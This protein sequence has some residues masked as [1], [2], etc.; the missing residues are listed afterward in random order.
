MTDSHKHSDPVRPLSP[1]EIKLVE[2]IDRSWTRERAL[3]ELKEHLQIAIE[4]ELATIPIYLYTYYSIDRTPASFPDSALSRFA[5]QAGAVIMSVAVEEMLHMSLSSN[6]LF[7]LGVQ[8]QLYLRSP[9]PYPTNLPGHQKLGPDAR[10]LALPLAPFSLQQLWQFL[11]I[12]Y[13]AASDAPPQGGAW[14]TIG[15]IY[16]YVRCIISC[17]HI[18]DADFHQGARLRQIQSTNYSPNNIDTVF[19]GGSFDKTCPVPAP[20][21]GSAATVAVYPSRGDSHAG[22]AQLITIDSRE[23]AL[24]AI[25][26]IDAQGE[27]FGTSK[28]D[29][30][31]KQEESHYYKF[32]SLQSQLAGYD[33]QHEHLP[34][35]PK[36]PAPAAR[37]FTPEELAQVVFDFP[38]NPV[39]SAYPAGRR[40]LA[41]VV[42]GLY[43]YM[44]I[45]TETIFLQEPARQ[46]LYFNQALH[47]SMIWILDKVIRTMRGVF[48]QQSSS[49]TGNPRLAPT[50]ENLD[51]GPRDQAFATLVTMCSELD[52]RYGNEPWYSQDLKYYVDMVPSLP[53]VS[54]FWAA[55]AQPGCDVSKYTG[56]PKFPASP[57][58]TVGDNEVRHACMGLNHCAGQGRTRDNACAG[59]GYCSTALEYNYAQPASPTVSDHTCHVKN[60]CAGQGGCGLYGTGEEQND[61]GHN[62]CATLGSCATP[63][64]AE[65]F[66]TD[67]PNRGKGVWLRARE[68]F[69]QKT[70]PSLRH[71]Q[72]KLPAQPPAVPHAQ[73]FQ[74][75]PTIEWIQ[76]YSGEGMTACGSSGMSGAG[77]CA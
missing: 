40:E 18:T 14:T 41:N 38:D 56:V 17:R 20:V 36:P 28:F 71:Q 32:L 74:Y 5:D 54:A 76:D 60:A 73:L 57:P 24:Q 35:H 4:V 8:P 9:A 21:A 39:A 30:P 27:G 19:P 48:L 65:R 51:L 69:T 22:R 55:P 43:Q 64:N 59:Q 61:P 37:Q 2:H 53:D 33:A 25:Q 11:E 23:T 29:D 66:S 44:L 46:K 45:L 26:T 62:Q 67:G 52:A 47:R 49:V 1:A 50:F 75:G 42:S 72:P 68:V 58:A 63:I 12:E 7:S 31:S 3:A 15:Q 70:W 6:V 10:P 16:S 77:S 13:P 34:K